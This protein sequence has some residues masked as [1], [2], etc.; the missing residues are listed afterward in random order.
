MQREVVEAQRDPVPPHAVELAWPAGRLRFADRP[1]APGPVAGRGEALGRHR[2]R[3]AVDAQLAATTSRRRRSATRRAGCG[4]PAGARA[5]VR[6]SG[7]TRTSTCRS[8]PMPCVVG[9]AHERS[10]VERLDDFDA[11]RARLPGAAVVGTRSRHRAPPTADRRAAP[12][13]TRRSRRGSGRRPCP[14]MKNA[15]RFVVDALVDAAVVEVAIARADVPHRQR[16]LM[17]RILVER[18]ELQ[19]GVLPVDGG[20]ANLPSQRRT[21]G[22]GRPRR[23]GRTIAAERRSAV[24]VPIGAPSPRPRRNRAHPHLRPARHRVPALRLLA[25]PRRRRRG[26]QGRRLRRAGRA[27]VQPRP[28]RDRALLDRRA[29]RRQAV[30]R[31]LR[32]AREVRRQGGGVRLRLARGPDP[33]RAPRLRR[34]G[35]RRV[36]RAAAARR[37]SKA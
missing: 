32:D 33:G 3:L 19:H 21:A 37:V 34:A 7:R 36:R 6:R 30:R 10:V 15:S 9:V 18:V 22:H 5:A 8:K 14:V 16:H 27:R 12:S 26:Q 31:R 17:D 2:D 20:A 23:V 4:R 25:L 24:L 28:A 13:R 29:H 11:V 1:D 35:A